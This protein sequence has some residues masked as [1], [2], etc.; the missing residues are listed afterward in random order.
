[1]EF[2]QYVFSSPYFGWLCWGVV[3]TLVITLVT[4][5]LSL[6]LGFLITGLRISSSPFSRAAGV[7]YILVFRNIPPVPLL[8]FLIVG[9]PGAFNS[10]VGHPFPRGFEF[11]LLLAGLSL[12]TSAYIADTLHSGVRGVPRNQWDAGRVMGLTPRSIR[13]SLI[14]PQALRIALPALGNRLIHNMKNSTMAL[15]IPLN[16]SSM[17]VLGQVGRVAGQ[18]FAWAEPLVFAALVHLGLAF[19]FSALL[20]H[21]ARKAQ[22]KVE[23]PG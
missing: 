11:Y 8:L 10:L 2:Q 6:M 21:L 4:T 20:N 22:E 14:Y 16:L 7:V 3:L 5:V 23:A 19:A 9:V 18:T 15:V 17:E 1:M 13:F 12:N